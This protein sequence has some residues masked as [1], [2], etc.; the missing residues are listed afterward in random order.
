MREREKTRYIESLERKQD[1]LREKT[2]F[3]ERKKKVPVE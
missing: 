3:I 1:I 2:R